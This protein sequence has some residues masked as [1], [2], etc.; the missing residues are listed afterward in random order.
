MITRS[1]KPFCKGDGKPL[2]TEWTDKY[3]G[4]DYPVTEYGYTVLQESQRPYA[5]VHQ[6]EGRQNYD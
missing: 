3:D 5:G 2:H 6:Q 1:F 4:K